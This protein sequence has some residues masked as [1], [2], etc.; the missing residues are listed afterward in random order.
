MRLSIKT[1]IILI[2]LIF[3]G[4]VLLAQNSQIQI[5]Q[6]NNNKPLTYANISWQVLNQPKWMGY[7]ASDEKGYIDIPVDADKEIIISVT[8]VGYKSVWDTIVQNKIKVIYVE[9][10]VLNLEQV[11]VTGTRT[12]HTL[13]RAPILT[14]VITHKELERIDAVT[15]T[16]VLEA[17]VPGIE[18]GRHGYGPSMKVQGLDP[19]YTLILIDGERMAG[20]T[21]GNVDYSRLNAANIERIE[22]LRGASSALYGSNAMGGV[23]NIITKKPQKKLDVSVSLRYAEKNQ[24]NY[25]K[26]KTFPTVYERDFF[27]NQDKLNLNGNINLG[28]RHKNFYCHTFV[29]YKS[30]DGYHIEDKERLEKKFV[31]I[32]TS[33]Y[34]NFGSST[35]SGFQNYTI[36]QK[37]GYTDDKWDV[38]IFGNYYEHEDFPVAL[39]D[40][41]Y[42]TTSV[43]KAVVEYAYNWKHDKFKNYTI[44]GYVNYNV[45]NNKKIR[46][47]HNTDVYD[48]FDVF[49]KSGTEVHN[50]R[51]TVNNT[52]FNYTLRLKKHNLFTGVENLYEIL[53]T[54]MFNADESM[55]EKTTNDVVLILQD[56][57]QLS[58]KLQAV[59]GVRGGYHTT[60]DFHASPSVTFKYN[61]NPFNI[62]LNYAMGYRAPTLKELFMDWSHMGMFQIVGNSDLKPETSNYFSFSLDFL[63]KKK[64]LNVTVITSYNDIKDKIDNLFITEDVIKYLNMDEVEIFNV[65]AILKWRIS[66]NFNFKGGYIYTSRHADNEAVSLS[67]VSPHALT[68]QLEYLYAKN[69]IKGSVNL[70]GKIYGKKTL[71][72]YETDVD[73]TDVLYNQIY[74]L[75]YPSYAIFNLTATCS[76]GAHI[77]LSAGAKN[78]FDYR[79]PVVTMNT[80]PTVG[81]RFF[82]ALTFRF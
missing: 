42:D 6:R 77:T 15:V 21:G 18:M 36:K 51:N 76:Y 23:I 78:I 7:A 40:Y 8:S 44:G 55:E 71:D 45:S 63:N 52:K 29:N 2:S 11:T 17:E 37:F 14:Q 19:Q 31:Y 3:T 65:E 67:D 13:K 70:S 47:S 64:N 24:K 54:D 43:D 4:E 81:R 5:V 56:E 69:K 50:Y 66:Q 41:R 25:D 16:D 10:D 22:I 1:L 27:K 74:E 20:E 73:E 9:E 61:I 30:Y 39:F 28:F 57:I 46:L 33:T 82:T 75:H 58:Q 60:F 35:I 34:Y 53:E 32:D 48:K 49:E 59:V 68:T 12:Q 80:T 79:A 62:R 26:N 38:Q 72:A